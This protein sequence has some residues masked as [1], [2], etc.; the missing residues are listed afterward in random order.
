MLVT[1]AAGRAVAARP[2]MRGGSGWQRFVRLFKKYVQLTRRERRAFALFAP[3]AV[4]LYAPGAAA[5]G[6]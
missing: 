4:F 3:G 6:R 2:A 1:A 5:P